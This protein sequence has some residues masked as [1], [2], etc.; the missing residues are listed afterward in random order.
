MNSRFLPHPSTNTADTRLDAQARGPTPL[1]K[2]A[3]DVALAGAGLA[4][5]I[6]FWGLIALLIRLEDGGP[7]FFRDRRV[8][9]GCREF[10][11]LK[12]RTMVPD[13]DRLC[14]PR[15][16]A[17]HDPRVTRIGRWLRATAMDELPQ[18]WN[19]LRGDM[20]FVGP[21]A[22]R[23]GEIQVQAA[24][25]D[26]LP[27]ESIPGY[28]ER[29][30]VVPGLTGLAQVYADRDVPPQRKFRYDRLYIRNQSLGLDLRLIAASVWITVRGAWERRGGK[31][32]IRRA[33]AGTSGGSLGRERHFPHIPG[34]TRR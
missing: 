19:I 21:R 12:F 18:L 7:V 1:V 16:A 11:V 15:Q 28:H 34:S 29:H 33:S 2:R 4:G 27:L 31:L 30:V 26:V 13:A 5:S 23:P 6:P 14:G 10:Q 9:L 22:L 24:A 8:G 25:D 20:S 3:L 32:G 17:E